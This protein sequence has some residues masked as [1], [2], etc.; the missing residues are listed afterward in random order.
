MPTCPN[1]GKELDPKGPLCGCSVVFNGAV[2]NVQGWETE[3]VFRTARPSAARKPLRRNATIG[4]G[5]AILLIGAAI[6]LAWPRYLA[7]PGPSAVSDETEKA[8]AIS[9]PDG[10]RSGLVPA[11][12]LIPAGDPVPEQGE[13]FVFSPGGQTSTPVSQRISSSGTAATAAS[14]I[15]SA[16]VVTTEGDPLNAHL[17]SDQAGLTADKK[18][19]PSAGEL[20][21]KPD[22]KAVLKITEPESPAPP[23]QS[24]ARTAYVGDYNLGPRGGCYLV[25]PSGG[26]KYVDRSLCTRSN[27]AAARQ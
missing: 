14:A 16:S 17:L 21:C 6:A 12:D 22:T 7:S 15:P 20:P 5:F 13:V 9:E 19:D 26:K 11:D 3:T 27:A 2:T 25:T 10:V 1:C 8:A 4:I 18:T 23:T 24:P